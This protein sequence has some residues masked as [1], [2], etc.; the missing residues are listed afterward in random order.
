M[1]VESSI[2]AGLAKSGFSDGMGPVESAR[3]GI[4]ILKGLTVAERNGGGKNRVMTKVARSVGMSRNSL[5]MI[6]SMVKR[7]GKGCPRAAS[8]L[9]SIS[10]GGRI[11]T[12]Y[13]RSK[14]GPGGTVAANIR[15]AADSAKRLSKILNSPPM[16]ISIV[17][18]RR[19]AD[20]I[21]AAL[22]AALTEIEK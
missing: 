19:E 11:M 14:K 8:A 6:I 22:A 13:N 1:S 7:A 3:A 16:T 10:G 21:H 4:T 17:A 12:E 18:S 15:T 9:E 5:Q 2:A 20:T